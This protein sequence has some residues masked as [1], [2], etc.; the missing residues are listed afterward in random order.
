M[1]KYV[2]YIIVTSANGY[3]KQNAKNYV[4]TRNSP[5]YKSILQVYDSIKINQG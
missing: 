4:A 2:I 3:I 5:K 1:I